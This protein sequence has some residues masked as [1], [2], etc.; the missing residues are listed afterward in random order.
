MNGKTRD[1]NKPSTKPVRHKK[2]ASG[3]E[4]DDSRPMIFAEPASST[5]Y[6][7]YWK[8]RLSLPFDEGN[9]RKATR[10]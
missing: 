10:P 6:L 5:H 8:M 1:G 2:D 3:N 7:R 9:E 4:G